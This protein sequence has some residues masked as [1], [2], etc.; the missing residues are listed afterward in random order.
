MTQQLTVAVRKSQLL[1]QIRHEA[2]HDTV[3]GLTNRSFFEAWVGD[4]VSVTDDKSCT[5]FIDLDRFKEVNDALGHHAGDALLKE[6]AN[7]IQH[8]CPIDGLTSRFGGDEFAVFVPHTSLAQAE[9][10]AARLTQA[11]EAPFHVDDTSIAVSP[12]I[13]IVE[14][15]THGNDAAKLLRR[16]D[17]AMYEA[18]KSRQ[19]FAVYN[20]ELEQNDLARLKL[21]SDLRAAIL[22]D[23]LQVHFQPQVDMRTGK[24]I[25][26]EALARWTHPDHG[27]VNP[28]VFVELAEDAGLIDP[29]TDR[30]LAKSISAAAQ[31]QR[32]GWDLNVAVNISARSFLDQNLVNVV[33][34]HLDEADL[35]PS[36]LTLEITES[37]MMADP[38]RTHE[39]LLVLTALGVT[40][41]V[42]DFG[43]G[44][45]SLSSLG[46][47]PVSELKIDRSFVMG[48]TTSENDAIIVR[49]TIDLAHNL[50]LKAVAEG[51]ETESLSATLQDLQCDLAQ[52][53]G[54]SRPLPLLGFNQWFV[55]QPAASRS[56]A[57]ADSATLL[58]TDPVSL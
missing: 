53:Y 52:G 10:L 57:E 25:G 42:D 47:F 34:R 58:Q 27:N 1:A 37:T 23:E 13:G 36:R 50:G 8:A 49:S 33:K 45:S 35:L 40:I 5:L 43:T 29:L 28:E 22:H 48:M 44:Y 38:V 21:L 16:A 4:A 6:V 32:R 3:T 55:D 18:K 11:V 19:R 9:E 46:Q 26:A 2:T 20:D 51:V 14:S 39:M 15:P 54:I 17:I 7:R 24:V 41:S 56:S 30:V 12:S 31:W